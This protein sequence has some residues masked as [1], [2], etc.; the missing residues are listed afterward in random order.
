MSK[1]ASYGSKE[2]KSIINLPHLEEIQ[3]QRQ[4]NSN[5]MTTAI[6]RQPSL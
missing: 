6:L 4:H 3:E 1:N 2:Q 5:M